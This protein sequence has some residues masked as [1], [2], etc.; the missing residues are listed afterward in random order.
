[1]GF[2]LPVLVTWVFFYLSL[3]FCIAWAADRGFI[4]TSVSRHPLVYVLSLGVIADSMATYG[5]IELAER[6]G[7]SFLLFYLGI[8]L[9]FLV[10]TPLVLP[11][12]RLRQVYQLSSLADLFTF[13]FRSTKV[14]MTVTLAMFIMLLPLFAMQIEAVSHSVV[15]LTSGSQSAT[16]DI[17]YQHY[18]ALLFSGFICLFTIL[19]GSREHSSQN[20]HDGLITAIAFESLIKLAAM[21]V[22][23][24]AAIYG[25]FGNI[26]LLQQWLAEH[27]DNA[28][29]LASPDT[30]ITRVLILMFTCGAIVMPHLYH[31]AFRE[32]PDPRHIALS[33]WALPLYLLLLSLP[34]LPL[35]WANISM[36]EPL[37]SAYASLGVGWYLKSDSLGLLG[38]LAG[39]SAASATMIVATLALANMALYHLVLPL[40]SRQTSSAK[41][42]YQRISYQRRITIAVVLFS[43]Y[44][45]ASFIEPR[46]LTDLGLAS[47]SGAVQLLPALIA[48]LYW[49]GANRNGL[50]WGL[51]IGLAFW[52]VLILLPLLGVTPEQW[53]G[54][55]HINWSHCILLAL[56]ANT[57]IFV[58]VSQLSTTR[59]SERIAAAICSTDRI[60]RAFRHP[61][62]VN[63]AGEFI[64]C[65]TPAL[66]EQAANKEVH[67]AM[68]ELQLDA[69]ESRPYAL[70][71]L[72]RQVEA[73]LSGL[74]GPTVG[75]RIMDTWL[76][77]KG[78]SSLED[79]TLIE[80]ELKTTPQPLQG[81]ARE[82]DK[83][84]RYYR[85]V[86]EN[87]PLGACQLGSDG[88]ILMWNRTMQNITNIDT[89]TMLGS[90]F[91][92]MEQPWRD[93]FEP[94]LTSGETLMQRCQLQDQQGQ[95]RWIS[96]HRTSDDQDT[97]HSGLFLVED[98]TDAQRL[99]QELLHTERLASIGR[100]AAGVA[101]EIGNPVTGIS[102]LAQNLTED[103]DPEE[104]QSAAQD[105][106][107]QTKRISRIVE[108]LVSF[109]HAGP[110]SQQLNLTPCNV[111]DCADEAIHLL[112]LDTQATAVEYTN[113]ADRELLVQADSQHLLQVFV[114]LL[115]NARDSCEDNNAI[116]LS[117]RTDG[118]QVD[119]LV[120]DNGSGIPADIQPQIF[121]PFFTTKEPGAGTGLGLSLV[122]NI[123][124]DM[125]GSIAVTSPIYSEG[126]PG[127]R[128]TVTLPQAH[129]DD[130]I[131]P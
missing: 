60:G 103:E 10:T 35:Y 83:L 97:L 4:P 125:H 19:F 21:L 41:N 74:L 120:E 88:E 109:S 75:T 36:S 82:V 78:D 96:L 30:G 7:Y 68:Q 117:A 112:S 110:L 26:E 124:V 22:L 37:S 115:S 104:V 49:P 118:E 130:I 45:F 64:Q 122:Y 23:M 63:S 71:Q 11:L 70:R 48:T 127:T 20:R 24:G 91:S 80:R 87:L 28:A 5:A 51:C 84:R 86:L 99:E 12:L 85:S 57:L 94:F 59:E 62:N 56:G 52:T 42:L 8:A 53:L 95:Q 14:G 67:K 46:Q 9:V 43:S 32:S 39:L 131:A 69:S 65:L 17:N 108:S 31:M 25:V 116:T 27:K 81:L 107:T 92:A 13:R 105:I 89:D 3:L 33:R 15:V 58:L 16:N 2:E 98:I 66:G 114:N 76:P 128:I 101:H 123:L 119:I 129:Y 40:R 18:L 44:G 93:I 102:C 47:F 1:M 77:A 126:S 100:L 6:F 72:R 90:S 73:R 38:F 106:L 79:F 121:E 34:V 61:V 29:K 55:E 54:A 111:A 113:L 50:L